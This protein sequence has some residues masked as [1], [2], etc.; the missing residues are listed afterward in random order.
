MLN[1]EVRNYL[2]HSKS[3]FDWEIVCWETLA[4]RIDWEVKDAKME[5]LKYALLS[6]I[7]K[8]IIEMSEEFYV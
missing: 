5:G 2:N 8:G 7:R 4:L 6:M 3:G 1:G